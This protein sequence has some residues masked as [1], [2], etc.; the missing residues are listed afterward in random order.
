MTLRRSWA[1]AAALTFALVAAACGGDD[2]E[3]DTA[4]PTTAAAGEDQSPT[5]A[6]DD[7][8]AGDNGAVTEA[9]EDGEVTDAKDS[10]PV[11]E[12]TPEVTTE[13]V[14]FGTPDGEE[15]NA[16]V[17]GEGTTGV[18]LAHMR[19]RDAST[20]TAFAPQAAAVGHQVLAFNFRGYGGSSG[21]ADTSLDVDLTAAVRFLE[22]RGVTS[23]VIAGASMGGTATI[24]VAAN[25]DTEGA[26]SLSAPA[27]FEGLEALGVVDQLGEPVL[28]VTTEGDQPYA[29]TA[30]AMAD[31]AFAS[32]LQVFDGNA[33]GTNIFGTHEAELTAVMLGFINDRLGTPG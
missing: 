24:N 26:I 25:L 32:Q 31:L 33:H 5:A 10:S 8:E 7:T 1:V 28:L 20:W 18:V 15:L 9:G 6:T 16:T 17:F 23:M 3:Q 21:I 27:N 19:G 22:S 2:A 12:E 30:V 14:R 4:T 11:A 13:R 29:D